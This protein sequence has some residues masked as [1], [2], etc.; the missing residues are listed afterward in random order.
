MVADQNEEHQDMLEK[1][2]LQEKSWEGI[3]EFEFSTRRYLA[4]LVPNAG[5]AHIPSRILG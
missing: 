5:N 1:W 3:Q 4:Q 2:K